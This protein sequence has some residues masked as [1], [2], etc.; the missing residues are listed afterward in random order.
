MTTDR[1]E[2]KYSKRPSSK[3]EDYIGRIEKNGLDLNYLAS[4]TIPGYYNGPEVGN[5]VSMCACTYFHGVKHCVGIIKRGEPIVK[6]VYWINR[7]GEPKHVGDPHGW[8][9]GMVWRKVCA[10]TIL[11]AILIPQMFTVQLKKDELRESLWFQKHQYTGKKPGAGNHQ[12]V[13]RP[14]LQLEPADRQ[15]RDKLLNLLRFYQMKEKNLIVEYS[16][17]TPEQISRIA[18]KMELTQQ[19]LLKVRTELDK[20]DWMPKKRAKTVWDNVIE[21]TVLTPTTVAN[22]IDD[23][24]PI[25]DKPDSPKYYTGFEGEY[26]EQ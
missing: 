6:L 23:R 20:H 25:I 2:A 7:S 18:K 15:A 22:L 24:R 4:W 26:D 1:I 11:K 19:N 5:K 21:R 17:A 12:A 10:D 16:K 14:K 9:R 3:T 8:K 13:G